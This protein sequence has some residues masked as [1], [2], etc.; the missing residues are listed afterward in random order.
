MLPT[1]SDAELDRGLARAR[2]TVGEL[3]SSVYERLQRQFRDEV[4]P[5]LEDV[6][7]LKKMPRKAR[8]ALERAAQKPAMDAGNT[9]GTTRARHRKLLKGLKHAR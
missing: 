2:T 7:S 5:V 9:V 1:M 8:R 4:A 3:P 6:D